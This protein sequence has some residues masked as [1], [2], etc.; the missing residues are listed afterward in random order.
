MTTH[1]A[2]YL[3]IL[4]VGL[5]SLA[6]GSVRIAEHQQI[7]F[8]GS[9]MTV[10][11]VTPRASWIEGAL[12]SPKLNRVFY[13][14]A[15]EACKS[16]LREGSSVEYRRTGGYGFIEGAG[17]RCTVSGIGSLRQ[18]RDSY[19]RPTLG[20]SAAKPR[21][22]AD[23]KEFYRDEE[24]T[25]VRGKFVLAS[26]IR[27]PRGDDTIAVFRND[28][29][30]RKALER[31]TGMMEFNPNGPHPLVMVQQGGNCPFE[32]LIRPE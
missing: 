28:P 14:P 5:T 25:M 17:V 26:Y 30:C 32:A 4:C 20:M 21:K 15:S 31:G 23:F 12:L 1:I 9:Q 19:G 29:L 27:W 10:G 8:T 6:C 22:R 3:A 18:W 16:L 11:P 24:V 7:P 2:R 13:F